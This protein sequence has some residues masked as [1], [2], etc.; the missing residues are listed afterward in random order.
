MKNISDVIFYLIILFLPTQLGKHFWPT[1]SYIS[2]IRIDYLSPTVYLTDIL[3]FSLF[4]TWLI[5]IFKNRK[6]ILNIKN[7]I[8]NIKWILLVI[9]LLIGIALSKSPLNGLYG[10][11]KLLEFIFLGLYISKSI[12]RLEILTTIFSI[13]ILFESLL[14]IIQFLQKSSIGGILYFFG[15]RTFTSDTPGI[16]NAVLNGELVLRPYATFP[17][18]NVLAGF[19]LIAMTII[20]FGD[21]KFLYVFV[22]A[23]G[24]IALFLTMSRVAILL[25]LLVVGLWF[26]RKSY[27][28]HLTS[29]IRLLVVLV[30]IGSI[31]SIIVLSPI[32]SRFTNFSLTDESIVMREQLLSSSLEMI[33]THPIFGVGLHNFLINLP[34]VQKPQGSVYSFQPVHNIYLLVLVETGIVG[35]T[36]FVW[37][38]L[39][40]YQRVESSKLKVQGYILISIVLVLALFDHYFLTLQQGQLLLTF[41]LGFLWI[42][43]KMIQ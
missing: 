26:I 28:L 41:V 14:A 13:G 34:D 9:F 27:I 3:I 4:A 6:E 19:L 21:R 5:S 29:S 42:S 2:G 10:F 11:F 1:F 39:K 23:I 18:P 37:L 15:E 40:T 38:F 17:H 7:K 16:A 20:M 22:L 24:T 8:V 35:F 32:S 12:L 43:R 36:F 31:G 25:W 30:L 33:K